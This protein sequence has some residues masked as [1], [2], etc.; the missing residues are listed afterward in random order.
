MISRYISRSEAVS[1]KSS[2]PNRITIRD[3]A[4]EAGVSVATVSR[5]MA[6]KDIVRDPTRKRVQEAVARLNY[7]IN[8]HASALAGGGNRS[9]AFLV[10]DVFGPSFASLARGVETEAADRGHLFLMSTTRG[11]ADR[12]AA[13]VAMMRVQ[14]TAAV[15]LVGGV[16]LDKA[17]EELLA[18]YADTLGVA[19]SRLVLCGRPPLASRP[20]VVSVQYDNV[21]AGRMATEH[22][23]R[24]GHR[25]ILFVTA[26]DQSTNQE[27]LEGYRAAL[28]DAGIA[29][30]DE[31]VLREPFSSPHGAE[32]LVSE[33]LESGLD[34]TALVGVSDAVAVASIRALRRAGRSIPGDVSVTGINDEEIAS[35]IDPG[36]TTVRIPFDEVGRITAELALT[37]PLPADVHRMLPVELIV[38]DSTAKLP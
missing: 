18:H 34:F 33:S 14:G 19:G 11:E 7:Q 5:V 38:R 3:V 8:P 29:F 15:I 28:A 36:L 24:L 23:V 31:L 2:S 4:R 21:A 10:R 13:L 26:D 17:Y 16:H 27:R 1:R 6:D 35:D 12:E 37:Q 9:I 22:L 32:R 25:R 30:A 20:D